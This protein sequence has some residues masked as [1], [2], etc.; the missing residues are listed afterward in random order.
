MLLRFRVENHRSIRDAQELLLTASERITPEDRRGTV[1]PV[2]GTQEAALPTVAFYGSN[3]SGKSNFLEALGL[4]RALIVSSHAEMRPVS[5]I[6][7]QSFLLHYDSPTKPTLLECTF[8]LSRAEQLSSNEQTVEEIQPVYTYGFKY[9]GKEIC[10]EWLYQE[11]VEEEQDNQLLFRRTTLEQEIALDLSGQLSGENES[12]RRLTRPNSLFL[13]A[14]AQNNHL[15]LLEIYKYFFGM[16]FIKQLEYVAESSIADR[17]DECRDKEK[18]KDILKQAD[19][20]I[21]D[22]AVRE[23]ELSEDQVEIVR[24]MS[25]ILSKRGKFE[26]EAVSPSPMHMKKLDFKHS[27]ADGEPRTLGYDLESRGTQV[28]LTLLL[29]ALEALSKGSLLVIVELDTSL[30]PDL[31]RAFLSLFHRKASNPH[32]AQL[33]FSTHDVTLLDSNVLEQD[34]IWFTDKDPDG[35]SRLTPLT[36]FKLPDQL[37]HGDIEQAYRLGRFGGVPNSREFLADL[38]AGQGEEK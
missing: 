11:V 4:M 14:A 2:P 30:H 36:D 6:P 7:Q 22:I 9:T 26:N 31:S 24:K 19:I 16:I 25:K 12:I 15:Q 29:P 27:T 34:E 1:F 10:E 18:L 17:V 20:G 23:I 35:A 32:G 38:N 37:R 8:T 13:S 33:L 5:P 28:F 3:A 21:T